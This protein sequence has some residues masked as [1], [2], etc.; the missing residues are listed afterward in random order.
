MTPDDRIARLAQRIETRSRQD[1]HQLLRAAEVAAL[2]R[3]GAGQLHAICAD[4]ADSV[5]RL[6]PRA[7]LELAPPEYAADLFREPGVNLMQIAAEGRLVQISFQATS[8]L[9]STEKFLTPYIL[10]G[11][12]RTYNQEMLERVEVQSQALFFCVEHSGNAWRF[13]DW[14]TNATGFLD[15]QFLVSLFERLV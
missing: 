9:Y 10:D 6:L 3:Q 12:V 1:E 8:D 4:F 14:R 2:R 13:V 15:R 11:E 5:N 7:V